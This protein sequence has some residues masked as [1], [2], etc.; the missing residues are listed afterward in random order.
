MIHVFR[1]STI[2]MLF[3]DIS[4]TFSNYGVI[5]KIPKAEIYM[6]F[7]T[8]IFDGG[9]IIKPT[10][11]NNYIEKLELIIS[12]L[13][14]SKTIILITMLNVFDIQWEQ[15]DFSLKSEIE[16]YNNT[17]Y[18]IA[19]KQNNI[20]IIDIEKFVYNKKNIMDWKYYYISGIEINPKLAFGFSQWLT[21][22]LNGINLIRKKCLVLD[23]DNTLWGGILG[24][25]GLSGILLNEDYPGKAFRDFQK[26]ILKSKENG[27]ILTVCSKNN[28]EDVEKL[29]KEHPQ[30]ILRKSD[31]SSMRINWN[32]KVTN[33]R[34]ISDELNIGLDSLVFFDDNPRERELVKG[35]LPD[36]TVPE[37]PEKP[38][39][40][41]LFFKEV[42]EQYFII[43]KLTKEDKDKTQQYLYNIQRETQ[44]SKFENFDSYI[45]ALGIEIEIQKA[46]QYN[47]ARIAQM[48]QKTN[49]FN[50]TTKRY[51]E[52]DIRN[53]IA[54]KNEI[55]CAS[56]KDRF[57]DN[58]ISA[59]V[60]IEQKNST[61]VS[62]DTLLMSCRILGRNIEFE[63]V[64]YILNYLKRKNVKN[65]HAEYVPTLK[66][67]QTEYFYDKL[68]FKLFRTDDNI[69]KYELKLNK[70]F[71]INDKYKIK[72]R[73]YL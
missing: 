67:K 5:S 55:L 23:L 32:D 35:I 73:F 29:F 36:V 49:Q 11:I 52:S 58:G 33:I 66:N 60:I 28:S 64:K 42:Y 48:T 19:L 17:L 59:L 8:P 38:Y 7:Y 69:K 27:V 63:F 53:L 50:L 14:E 24:E 72:E 30:M 10:T 46:D 34:E 15:E 41:P 18:Q 26:L 45:E 9:I 39:N 47:I 6:W 4:C 12:N 61:T 51:N 65:V 16:N 31:F 57:G 20:K 1:N 56:I 13:P 2:E 54:N 40:L 43:Y 37:F 25:D 68:E 70:K 22:Q 3:N 44:K 21:S 62:F 71:S